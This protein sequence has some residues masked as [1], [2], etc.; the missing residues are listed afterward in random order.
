M[1]DQARLKLTVF[2]LIIIMFISS[3]FSVVVY[4]LI[5]QEFDR[6]EKINRTRM[7]GE[8][9]FIKLQGPDRQ[10]IF[11][12]PEVIAESKQRLQ[13]MLIAI[14]LG[15]LSISALGGYYLAGRTLQPIK[16]MVDQQNQF[17]TDASHEL[18]TPLT[19]LKTEIE[20]ALRDNK[21]S[22]KEA[23]QL[24]SSNLE[25]VNSLQNLS[26]SLIEL[27]HNYSAVSS[28]YIDKINLK[29]EADTAVKKMSAIAKAKHI[30]VY[31]KI[32]NHHIKATKGIMAEVLTIF[33]DNA[34]KYSPE[35]TEVYLTSHLTDG[36]VIISIRDQG[37]GI[38]KSD[39]PKIFNRF[40]RTDESRSK[41]PANGFGLGLSI[42]QKH[43]K[44][45]QGKIEVTSEVNQG[46]TF[47]ISLPR[48]KKI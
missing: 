26:E 18:K 13:L 14:N 22:L 35:K 3:L 46:T 25:E 16:E 4:R 36:I 38:K 32:G 20:V 40:F 30:Q 33:I 39:Q 11:I 9:F 34:I 42:A 8:P 45:L 41:S 19:A 6:I 28:E 2:Y 31:N 27:S 44:N 37:Y 1:F 21:L 29:D 15:I 12:S 48:I 24:L 5:T 23:K 17:I 10:I 7:E 43:I 47:T